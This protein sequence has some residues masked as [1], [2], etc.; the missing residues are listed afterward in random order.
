M[1]EPIEIDGGSHSGSG[2]IV[3]Q[4]VAYAALTRRAVR[5]VRAR[6]R[7]PRPGLAHQ[8]LCAVRAIRDLVGGT[9]EGDTLGSQVFVFHPGTRSPDGEFRWDV[10][11]AGS[12]TALALALL[13]LLTRSSKRVELE[14]HG[15]LFQDAAPSVFHLQHVVLPLVARMGLTAEAQM[16]RPGYVP[17]GG[18]VLRLVRNAG[19][20]T[21]R[22]LTLRH[23]GTVQRIWGLALASHLAQRRVSAPDGGR[24]APG[25]GGRGTH[26]RIFGSSTTR[27]RCRPGRRWHSLRISRAGAVSGRIARAC[28]GAELRRSA[29][30]RL[31]SSSG[32]YEPEPPS[33]ASPSIRSSRSP[34]S[35]QACR[36]FASRARPSTSRRAP[37]S[38]NCFSVP[39]S[40][41]R[42]R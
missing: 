41:S 13:P 29:C 26:R 12:V 28:R 4:S 17:R 35:P 16:V 30:G 18:G 33:T 42:T 34:P 39:K 11:S 1:I 25:A 2:S 36:T 37:G 5:V 24:G 3:R 38:R 20:T 8:H 23:A 6:A 15:G 22:P 27:A 21:L 14:L 10:G 31:A 9:L 32:S 19:S 7:R 40:A